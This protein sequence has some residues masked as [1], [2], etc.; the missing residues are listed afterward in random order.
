MSTVP[1]GVTTSHATTTLPGVNNLAVPLNQSKGGPVVGDSLHG[2]SSH[3]A[4]A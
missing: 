2:A 1:A 4:G 3:D